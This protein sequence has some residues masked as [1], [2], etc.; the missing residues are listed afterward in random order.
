MTSSWEAVQQE[1]HLLPKH[2][3]Q[4]PAPSNLEALAVVP[5]ITLTP[6][7]RTETALLGPAGFHSH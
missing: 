7:L 2:E 4:C 5:C 1:A 6:V 3:D